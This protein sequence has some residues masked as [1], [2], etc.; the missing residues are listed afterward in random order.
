MSTIPARHPMPTSP[1]LLFSWR[2]VWP[3]NLYLMCTHILHR[4]G[5]GMTHSSQP[6][7]PH[8][9]FLPL[10]LLL[11]VLGAILALQ[12]VMAQDATGTVRVIDIDDTITP[13]M[14]S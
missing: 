11:L 6:Q 2:E 13:A 12:P 7:P 3:S 14:A 10:S 1:S 5:S 4:E 8:R 9:R